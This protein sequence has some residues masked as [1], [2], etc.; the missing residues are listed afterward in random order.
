MQKRAINTIFLSI[1]ALI[2]PLYLSAQNYPF[3]SGEK[4]S[5]IIHYKCGFSADLGQIDITTTR[6]TDNAKP[7]FHIVANASTYKSADSFFKV[8]DLYES[9]F[10]EKDLTPLYFHRDVQEGKYWA[11]N[12]YDWKSEGKQLH[13]IVDKKNR[14]H[15]DTVYNAD[16]VIRDILNLFY[17]ARAM[18]FNSFVKGKN[19]TTLLAVDKDI[20][21]LVLRYL[22]KEQKKI[23]GL[24]TFNTIKI[25]ITLV[26][27]TEAD[28]EDVDAN[29]SLIKFDFEENAKKYNDDS[30]FYGDEKI[31]IWLSDDQNRLPLY[32]SAPVVVGSINGRLSSYSGL[33]YPL[34]SKVK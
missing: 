19:Y 20:S 15:R 5:I 29:T 12:W 9:K 1:I 26:P 10:Y 25:G 17:S 34:T 18:D 32:F 11:K 21:K 2:V 6:K 27:V 30:S 33:K 23:S 14:P 16:M 22:G 8:R 4:T 7:Y 3:T 13:A 31:F 24:G 28:Q